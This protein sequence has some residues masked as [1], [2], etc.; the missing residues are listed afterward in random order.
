M[1]HFIESFSGKVHFVAIPADQS[2]EDINFFLNKTN[3][4]QTSFIHVI[5][6]DKN[7]LADKFMT[8]MLLTTIILSVGLKTE[9]RLPG[10]IEWEDPKL[11]EIF[12]SLIAG[13]SK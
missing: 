13:K 5:R 9:K 2:D 10:E 1:I 4:K 3:V 7:K 12:L 6:D 11:H 8:K